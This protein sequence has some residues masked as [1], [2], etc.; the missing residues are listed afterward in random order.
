MQCP[1]FEAQRTTM[2]DRIDELNP[3][4]TQK[5][6]ENPPGTIAWLLGKQMD[7]VSYK[8]MMDFW[9]IAGEAINNMYRQITAHK[10]DVG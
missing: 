6:A 9:I 10:I 7:G 8:D 1:G 5:I 3:M 4:F 2:Y